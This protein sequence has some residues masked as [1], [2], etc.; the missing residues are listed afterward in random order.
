VCSRL[1][2]NWSWNG[3]AGKEII[4]TPTL[5][6]VEGD[7]E[8]WCSGVSSA[9]IESQIYR[10]ADVGDRLEMILRSVGKMFGHCEMHRS[11]DMRRNQYGN[12]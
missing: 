3:T 8:S 12:E 5:R 9:E 11:I 7:W 1:S 2:G 6:A 10:L 4:A